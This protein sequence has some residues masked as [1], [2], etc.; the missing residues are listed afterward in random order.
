VKIQTPV[1]FTE[2]HSPNGMTEVILKD[3][4]LIQNDEKLVHVTDERGHTIEVYIEQEIPA[5]PPRLIA[6]CPTCF[7]GHLDDE[8][9]VSCGCFNGDG[10]PD[11]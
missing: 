5:P 9:C 3:A 7:H 1:E 10:G 4:P 6:S 11:G 2:R 8:E